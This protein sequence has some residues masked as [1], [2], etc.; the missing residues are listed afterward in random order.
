M[1]KDILDDEYSL[2]NL[3]FVQKFSTRKI[4]KMC[5][6]HHSTV[7]RKIKKLN[8]DKCKKNNFGWDII[9]PYSE[10]LIHQ[11]VLG[12][13]DVNNSFAENEQ[14]TNDA[15]SKTESIAN[16]FAESFNRK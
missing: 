8:L 4:A 10:D 16:A 1:N 11:I 9:A 15:W 3:H 2:Y 12:Q 6:V 13:I 14:I 5:G 7:A